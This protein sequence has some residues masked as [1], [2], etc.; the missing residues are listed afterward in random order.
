MLYVR[1]LLH[2]LEIFLKTS[3]TRKFE[4]VCIRERSIV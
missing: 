1:K 3:E 2:Y 4:K